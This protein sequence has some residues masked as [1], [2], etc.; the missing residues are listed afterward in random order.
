MDQWHFIAERKIREAMEEGAFD[1]LEGA[2][3]PLDLTEN[4]FED[5]SQRMAHRLL[6]NNGFAPE[7]IEEAKEIEAESRRLRDHGE[8]SSDDHRNRIA[9]LNRRILAFNLKAPAV[10]LHKRPFDIS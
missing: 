9:A 3:K 4:P 2:G 6:K 8:S 5:P 10:S 7:W 1:H